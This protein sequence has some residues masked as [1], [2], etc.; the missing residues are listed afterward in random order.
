MGTSR[1]EGE[2]E[3]RGGDG[4][5]RRQRKGDSVCRRLLEL[6]WVPSKGGGGS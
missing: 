6:E 1:R 5:S 3:N 4:K 2:D